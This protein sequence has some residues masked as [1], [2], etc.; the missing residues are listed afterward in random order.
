M[1]LRKI[2]L[3]RQIIISSGVQWEGDEGWGRGGGTPALPGFAHRPSWRS[4][5]GTE[6]AG[7]IWGEVEGREK[8]FKN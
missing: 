1:G 3:K 7:K 2:G 5:A 8:K 6:Q 4:L